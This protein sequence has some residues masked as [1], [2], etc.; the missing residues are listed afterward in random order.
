MGGL[1]LTPRDSPHIVVLSIVIT[2]TVHP[3]P[4]SQLTWRHRVLAAILPSIASS[5]VFVVLSSQRI[6]RLNR[7]LPRRSWFEGTPAF[8][9]ALIVG[10][11]SFVLTSIA[12]TRVTTPRG[13]SRVMLVALAAFSAAAV[14]YALFGPPPRLII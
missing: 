4:P 11:C 10:A 9:A 12:V 1:L 5:F 13:L 3:L 6:E 14:L 7:G 2:N 8:E